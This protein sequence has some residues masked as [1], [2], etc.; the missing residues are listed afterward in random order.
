MK[1]HE[2][3]QPLELPGAARRRR[4]AGGAERRAAGAAGTRRPP[5]AAGVDRRRPTLNVAPSAR[6]TSSTVEK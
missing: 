3:G 6:A 1:T 4:G 5:R 2:P